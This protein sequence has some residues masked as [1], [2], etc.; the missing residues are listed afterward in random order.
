M[1]QSSVEAM[2]AGAVGEWE[3]PLI[4]VGACHHV[5]IC[6]IKYKVVLASSSMQSVINVPH[7][8]W[9]SGRDR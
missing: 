5:Y 2:K 9:E 6:M 4:V 1:P 3:R 8:Q 7:M